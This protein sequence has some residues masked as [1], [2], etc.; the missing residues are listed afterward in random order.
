MSKKLLIETCADEARVAIVED[1]RLIDYDI[2]VQSKHTLKGN[3]YKGV[4]ANVERALAAAFVDFGPSKQGFLPLSELHPEAVVGSRSGNTEPLR[5]AEQLRRGHE[6][7]V[8]VTRDEIGHKGAAL[9]SFLSI[10]GRYCVLMH[11]G[12]GRGGVSRKIEDEDER[13]KAREILD[14]LKVPEGLGVIVRTAGMGRTK[15]EL[16][17]DLNLLQRTWKS[18]DKTARIGRAPT[19]LYREPDLV[20]RTIR[21]YLLPDIDQILVDDPDEYQEALEFFNAT[22]PRQSQ[23]LT[24]Y[25]G[26]TPLLAAHGVEDAIAS[27][28]ERIVKL[29]SGGEIVI[30]QTEALVAIDVNSARSTKE[31]GHEDTVYKTNLEAAVEVARQLRLRDLGGIIVVDFIDH[32][33]RKHDRDV[34]KALK[35]ALKADKAKTS[36]GHI[37]RNGTLELTRQRLR[38]AHDAVGSSPCPAC[39]GSGRIRDPASRASEVMRELRRRATADAAA[40]ASVRAVVETDLANL[41][42]SQRRGELV[43]LQQSSGVEV[44]VHA[45]EAPGAAPRY[46]ETKRPRRLSDTELALLLAPAPSV[47]Q[48]AL[49]ALTLALA[50]TED[51]DDD[52]EPEEA[53]DADSEA[54]DPPES[55]TAEV[56]KKRRRRRRKS[57]KAQPS[58]VEANPEAAETETVSGPDDAAV[59]SRRGKVTPAQ[60]EVRVEPAFADPLEEALFGRGPLPADAEIHFDQEEE[61]AP[62]DPATRRKRR[63]RRRRRPTGPEDAPGAEMTSAED[64]SSTLA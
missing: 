20:V 18:V 12:D 30:D 35:D 39:G 22:M 14:K 5:S 7:V 15:T 55:G 48:A 23:L 36:L 4:V 51:L 17:R 56:R 57:G 40:V 27:T 34:E 44:Y 45:S 16:Q 63:R 28:W 46:L 38:R 19:L 31:K 49:P 52:E 53:V 60:P 41:L 43:E 25:Q 64:D 13:K 1:G 10:A 29:P 59:T 50:A 26:S 58:T 32:A 21:D 33:Q 54:S 42:N 47:Q 61:A 9:T 3:I 62:A 24:L 6:V 2:E 37:S 8:Q 11:S